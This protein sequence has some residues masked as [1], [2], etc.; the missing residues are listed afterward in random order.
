MIKSAPKVKIN[1]WSLLVM[2]QKK[3]LSFIKEISKK[4]FFFFT[5][6]LNS[7]SK[8]ETK[9]SFCFFFSLFLLF[10]FF[11]LFKKECLF[12]FVTRVMC[13]KIRP[14]YQRRFC[15]IFFNFF[16]LRTKSKPE[17]H[18]VS[19]LKSSMNIEENFEFCCATLF[20][21]GESY[22]E[23]SSWHQESHWSP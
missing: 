19:Y 12:S 1:L 14:Q 10:F 11:S 22:C 9:S 17:K 3:H 7:F 23:Y 4:F 6:N 16:K 20:C 15:Y 8:F 5:K 21:I 2:A 13:L 18:S